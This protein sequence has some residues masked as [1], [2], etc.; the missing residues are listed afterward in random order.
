LPSA[1]RKI[2]MPRTRTRWPD[3]GTPNASPVCTPVIAQLSTTR[4]SVVSMM[5]SNSIST[6]VKAAPTMAT[7]SFWASR[8]P[9]MPVGGS[10]VTK[11]SAINSSS[12]AAS[13]FRKL[14]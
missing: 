3:G 9:G 4:P 11:S 10:W 5:S 12:R 13:P 7:S 14:S 2:S 6:S 8:F 1:Q